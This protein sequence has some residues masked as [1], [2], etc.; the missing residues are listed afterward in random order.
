M[1]F[2][3]MKLNNESGFSLVELM[4]VVAIIGILAAMSVGQIGKQV[5]KARQS[6][7]KS[8][9]AALYTAEKTFQ[10]EF[11]SYWEQFTPIGFSVEGTT[12]YN[13][14]F[15]GGLGVGAGAI[16]GYTGAM[17]AANISLITGCPITGSC[18]IVNT[19]GVAPGAIDSTGPQAPAV[20]NTA[21]ATVFSAQGRAAIFVAGTIDIW[22]INNNKN[23][24]NAQNGIP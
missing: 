7:V 2:R 11:G 20:A 23:L 8:N 15:T 9:L 6:E 24:F 21:T 3:K 12:R 14:G 10:S 16:P 17:P 19:N 5:A 1:S 22:T 18:T 4:V 13:V